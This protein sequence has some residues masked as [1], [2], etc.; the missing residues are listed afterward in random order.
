MLLHLIRHAHALDGDD[1][2]ARPLSG[3]GRTQVRRIA[4]LLRA[5]GVFAPAEIWHSPL[6]RA[7]QT[8]ELFARRLTLDAPRRAVAG[9]TPEDD[10][11]LMVKRLAR[12]GRALA[13]VGHDPHL[14]ALASLLVAG[15]AAPPVFA[16]KKCS[17]LALEREAGRWV[18]RWHVS[19]ELLA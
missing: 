18:V 11:R 6:V 19:P 8:A 14:S 12:E 17:V 3:K 9:L 15:V 2:A 4:A 1:D 16:L 13:L 5:S 7:R 10:P